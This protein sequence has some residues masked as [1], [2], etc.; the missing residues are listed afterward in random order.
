M[1]KFILAIGLSILY[2]SLQKSTHSGI[3]VHPPQMKTLY[4]QPPPLVTGPI[5]TPAS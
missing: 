2:G 5:E 1:P 4:T 3:F